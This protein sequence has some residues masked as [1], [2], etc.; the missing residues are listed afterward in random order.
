LNKEAT[1]KTIGN[2]VDKDH[3]DK[4]FPSVEA[5]ACLD[6]C[7]LKS[8]NAIVKKTAECYKGCVPIGKIIN[9]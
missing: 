7:G 1:C 4:D 6:T 5:N 9:F 8:N 2:W 3:I